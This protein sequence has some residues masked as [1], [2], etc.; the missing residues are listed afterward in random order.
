[1]SSVGELKK[2]RG[3]I[4]VLLVLMFF[5][6]T[7]LVYWFVGPN[8]E[9]DGG[10]G[11][12]GNSGPPSGSDKLA[13]VNLGPAEA[14]CINN[15]LNNIDLDIS[16]FD[17]LIATNG[18]LGEY[19]EEDIKLLCKDKYDGAWLVNNSFVALLNEV[20][21]QQIPVFPSSE[22]LVV[23]IEEPLN[24]RV[25]TSV[26]RALFENLPGAGFAS[27]IRILPPEPTSPFLVLPEGS[28]GNFPFGI[29]IITFL[30]IDRFWYVNEVARNADSVFEG[31]ASDVQPEQAFIRNTKIDQRV[32]GICNFV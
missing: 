10:G 21:G 13:L 2:A 5:L 23:A 30:S 26:T 1:M 20:T 27:V 24:P 32:A 15:I 31:N 17:A 9:E 19:S 28:D 6:V 18:T 16:R 22:S 8:A 29:T 12:G 11:G 7:S 14:A 25:I 4:I 3:V